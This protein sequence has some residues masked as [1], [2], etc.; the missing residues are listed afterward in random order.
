MRLGI[1]LFKTLQNHEQLQFVY[2]IHNENGKNDKG[3]LGIILPQ[4]TTLH[5]AV[6]TLLSKLVKHMRN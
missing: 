4:N 2:S 3:V 6:S 5:F 1:F